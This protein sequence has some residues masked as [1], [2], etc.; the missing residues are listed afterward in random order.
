MTERFRPFAAVYAMLLKDGKIFLIRRYQ[1]GW[2]DGKYTLPS[3]HLDGE[4][5][6][7]AAM[8]RE[9]R[10]EAGVE[11]EPQDLQFAHVMHRV[12]LGEREYVDFFFVTEKWIG[13][14]YNAEKHKADEAQWFPVDKLPDNTIDSVRT[15]VEN[16][17][18]GIPFSEFGWDG[19]I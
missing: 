7:S 9:V 16:Y 19:R 8:T 15:A 1:T 12:R 4:E 6:V 18:K 5:S 14:P 13:E 10:E 2:Q 3:G 17:R 11:I